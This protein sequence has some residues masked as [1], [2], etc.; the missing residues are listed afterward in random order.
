[1]II[2]KVDKLIEETVDKQNIRREQK[3]WLWLF[4][5]PPIGVYKAIKFKAF[6]KKINIALIIFMII[7]FILAL[8]TMFY[9]NRVIDYK[10]EKA[11]ESYTEDIGELRSYV[12]QGTL[13]DKFFIYSM[14]TTKGEYDVYFSGDGKLNIQYIYQLTPERKVVYKSENIPKG[15][16]DIYPEIIRFFF[17]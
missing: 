16:D 3:I 15:L 11:I 1:M 6:D 13:D 2:K 17:F 5:F 8:D 9:P 12:K 10:V 4:L 7:G 14:I